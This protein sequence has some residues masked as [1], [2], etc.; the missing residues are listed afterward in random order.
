MGVVLGGCFL[1]HFKLSV[2][3]LEEKLKSACPKE[4]FKKLLVKAEF[5]K[6]YPYSVTPF[7]S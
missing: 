6:N 5:P 3:M 7:T 1:F 4:I 2:Y